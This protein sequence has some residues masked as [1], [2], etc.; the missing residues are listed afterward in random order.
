MSK[1]TNSSVLFWL[2]LAVA[3]STQ[4]A[5]IDPVVVEKPMPRLFENILPCCRIVHCD[6]NDPDVKKLYSD[7]ITIRNATAVIG[8]GGIG[9]VRL[10]G[11]YVDPKRFPG[12]PGWGNSIENGNVALFACNL[13][14]E[15]KKITGI[16][17]TV[18]LDFRLLYFNSPP[19]IDNS[20]YPVD[21]LRV[22]ILSERKP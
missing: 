22:K 18:E 21:L 9:N 8:D 4:Q 11:N 3:C 15:F 19:G 5:A 2:F 16:Y 13:P 1:P 10:M 17:Y 7:S 20:G 14:D 6:F 12:F